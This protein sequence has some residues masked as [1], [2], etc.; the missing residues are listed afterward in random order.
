[1]SPAVNPRYSTLLSLKC[2]LS[3][4]KKPFLSSTSTLSPTMTMS[5]SFSVTRNQLFLTLFSST[6]IYSHN[7]IKYSFTN[8]TNNSFNNQINYSSNNQINN[9]FNSQ[10]NNSSNKMHK[11]RITNKFYD[12]KFIN[13][14]LLY[15]CFINLYIFLNQLI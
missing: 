6:S 15:I 2:L 5:S 3:Q 7:P 11:F 4:A 8:Q 9:S 1:M 12:Y 13:Y 14:F 10:I